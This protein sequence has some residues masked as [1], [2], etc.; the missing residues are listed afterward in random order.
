MKKLIHILLLLLSFTSSANNELFQ[1]AN[2][3][4]D[5]EKYT[6]ACLLYQEILD[7]GLESAELYYNIGNC[8]YKNKDWANAIWNY[9]KSLQK[10]KNEKTYNNLEITRLHIIDHIESIPLIF[11]TKWWKSLIEYY[12]VKQ[13]QIITLIMIWLISTLF[14]FN[15]HYRIKTLF[16]IPLIL[17]I[18]TIS[19]YNNYSKKQA[20]IFSSNVTVKS[21]PS[22]NST[23]LF[24][25]HSDSLLC[26]LCHSFV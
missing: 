17:F 6:E 7:D 19:S 18:I 15:K 2:D 21:A 14:F 11:Y 25:L 22:E 4:Y 5:Q 20:I 10:K 12:T 3:L 26:W 16:F 24:L 1:K 9:E 13:W 8:Y 23:D